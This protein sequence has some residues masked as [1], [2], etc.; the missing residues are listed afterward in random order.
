MISVEGSCYFRFYC[1]VFIGFLG[2]IMIGL[3][4]VNTS[5]HTSAMTS[6][7][8]SHAFW[9]RSLLP[10]EPQKSQV[11][12]HQASW[13]LPVDRETLYN[14]YM[15]I[16]EPTSIPLDGWWV[17]APMSFA[18]KIIGKSF[19]M[20]Y[21]VPF[22]LV[23]DHDFKSNTNLLPVYLL[24]PL[25]GKDVKMSPLKERCFWIG[26]VQQLL[27]MEIHVDLKW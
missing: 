12:H 18:M 23:S 5:W 7:A 2:F 8:L 22:C 10:S 14:L 24:Y 1:F 16:H 15:I 9:L 11:E 13:S 19:N 25:D 26:V 3:F 27:P 4:I 20:F 6:G 21:A 17:M